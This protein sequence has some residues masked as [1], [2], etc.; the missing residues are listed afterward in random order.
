MCG[1]S[2]LVAISAFMLRSFGWRGVPIFIATASTLLL[3][4]LQGRFEY[5]F[6]SLRVIGEMSGVSESLSSAL[7]VL[8]CG[9]LFG[10]CGDIC[11]ELGE[12][13]VAK[14]VDIVGRVE[15]IA[16][17]V[18]YFEQIINVGIDLIG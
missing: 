2:L 9:Y 5:I 11:R 12:S 13:G 7:K 14:T 3:I 18:P 6:D 15:I 1:I 8:S 16:I 10:I 17:V 4:E